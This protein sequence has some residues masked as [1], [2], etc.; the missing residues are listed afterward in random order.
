MGSYDFP[1]AYLN[2]SRIGRAPELFLKQNKFQ[3][4]VMTRND[5][6]WKE[7]TLNDGTRRAEVA[8]AL[9]GTIE[10]GALWNEDV[11]AVLESLGLTQSNYEQCVFLSKTTR[12]VTYVDDLF[13]SCES[14]EDLDVSSSVNIEAK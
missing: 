2:A 6:N 13:I 10:A 14:E 5:P 9:Y 8:G 12:I 3:T 1:R 4:E 11:K 7:Y